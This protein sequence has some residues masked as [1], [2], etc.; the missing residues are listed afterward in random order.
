VNIPAFLI[1][2][3]ITAF[4]A[5]VGAKTVHK[6]N[7]KKVSVYFGIFLLIIGTNFLIEYLKY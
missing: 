2:F 1:F 5:R 7:K 3:P 4:M 6:I